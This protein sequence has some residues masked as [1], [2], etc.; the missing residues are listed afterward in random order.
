M[1]A[2]DNF[3]S[4]VAIFDYGQDSAGHFGNIRAALER[5]GMIMGVDDLYIAA[6]APIHGLTL[7]TNNVLEFKR[8]EGL[9]IEDWV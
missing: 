7:N 2:V 4:R 3:T 9:G 8:V 1:A 5:K 6:H